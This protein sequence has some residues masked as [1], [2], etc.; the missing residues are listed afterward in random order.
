[1]Q[2]TEERGYRVMA[3]FHFIPFDAA[4]NYSMLYTCDD[5]VVCAIRVQSFIFKVGGGDILV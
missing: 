1:M 3:L 5:S 4:Y 2:S